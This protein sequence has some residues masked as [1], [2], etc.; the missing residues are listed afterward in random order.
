ME[1]TFEEQPGHLD[2]LGTGKVWLRTLT[3]AYDANNKEETY[4]VYTHI[5]DFEGDSP[6]TKGPGGKYSHHRGLFIGWKDTLVPEG[7]S[8]RDLDTWHMENCYQEHAAWLEK[9]VG[10]EQ[11]VQVEEIL[12]K[13]EKHEPFIREIRRI[14]AQE[15]P[16][17]LR[18]LDFQSTLTS[19]KGTIQLRGDSHH[20]GMQVRMANEVAEHEETTEYI[21]PQGSRVLENDEVAGAWWVCC[22]SVVRGTRYWVVHMTPANH[23]TGQP[24]YSVRRYARFG[25]FFETELTQERPLDLHFRIVVSPTALDEVVCAALYNEYGASHR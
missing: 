1:F 22:S 7:D 23:P 10:P 3:M 2:L 12:W 9:K 11:A 6:I 25:A 19:L 18:I 13:T 16:D 24:V 17:G 15:K 4:K 5:Y 20:A 21:L 14:T 8:V